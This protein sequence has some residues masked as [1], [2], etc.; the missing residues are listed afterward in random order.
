MTWAL[1]NVKTQSFS[2]WMDDLSQT[3][4]QSVIEEEEEGK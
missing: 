3:A 4:S 2:V 1:L